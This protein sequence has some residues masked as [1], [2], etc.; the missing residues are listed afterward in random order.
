MVP[1]WHME[2]TNK[3]ASRLRVESEL[4]CRGARV[5][6]RRGERLTGK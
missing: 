5:G 1:A 2:E 3:P 4:V 6:A